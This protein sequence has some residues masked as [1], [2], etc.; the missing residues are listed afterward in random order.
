MENNWKEVKLEELIKFGNGKQRPNSEG[1]IP[2]YGGNGILSYTESSNYDGETLIIGRV[3]AYCGAVYYDNRPIWISDNA[4]SGKPKD[5]YDTKFLYYFLKNLDLNQY[6]GG[7]SH[8][9]VTQTLLNSLEFNVCID[10]YEQKAIASVLSSL[11]DKIDLLHQQ[12]QTLEALAETLFRQW[13]IEE[14]KEDWEELPFS[15]WIN[16]TVGGDWGKETLQDEFTKEV[17]CIRGTDIADLLIGIPT[18]TPIRFVKEKKFQSIEPKE[19]DI[20]IEISGGTENQSTGRAYF[21]NNEIKSLFGKDLVFS[22]FCRLI[23]IKDSNYSFFVYL[24]LKY[25]YDQDEFFNLEN[26]SSGIKNLDYKSLLFENKYKMPKEDLVLK[27]NDQV[28][29]NYKKINQ[30]KFQIQTLTQLRDTLL[31]K[32]MSGEVR[33]KI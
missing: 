30:N 10:A 20:I 2:V 14:A 31:P 27:F 13:F 25:L 9:L 28:S 17:Y 19:G 3:G 26:G 29:N 4:L 15:E 1:L 16:E 12:N 33:V 11:D 32:L 8:P 22:N 23:R 7:S 21:I 18:K 6:A 5:N 24:Y